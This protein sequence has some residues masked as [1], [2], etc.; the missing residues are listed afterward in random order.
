MTASPKRARRPLRVADKAGLIAEASDLAKELAAEVVPR[1]DRRSRS[2]E[3]KG[4]Q[5]NHLDLFVDFLQ[6]TRSL[7]ALRKLLATAEQIDKA[8]SMNFDNPLAHHTTVAKILLDELERNPGR[9]VDRWLWLL[10]WTSR[11]LKTEERERERLA[12]EAK[13]RGTRQPPRRQQLTRQHSNRTG[14]FNQMQSSLAKLQEQ[15]KEGKK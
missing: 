14:G 12:A 4:I 6:S 3:A 8:R 10:G 5:R 9:G 13:R 11:L 1:L 2:H 7:E 15:I